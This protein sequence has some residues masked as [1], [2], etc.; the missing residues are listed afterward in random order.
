LNALRAGI[1]FRALAM[2]LAVTST[3]AGSPELRPFSASYS[4][5]GG[6]AE[7]QLQPLGDERWSYQLRLK[8]NIFMRL[9]DTPAELS[10]SVF[11]IQDGRV[12]A[13]QF[14]AEDRNSDKNQSL[15]FD[16]NR[17][18]V[19]GTFERAPVDLPTQPGLLDSLSMQVAL[20]NELQAGR[21][22]QQF[23]LVEKGRIREYNYTMEGSA[24][25]TTAVGEYRTVIY[26][27]TR[28]GSKKSTW[29]WCA[30]ELGHLPLKV[31]RRDGK[32]LEWSM[33]VK[34]LKMEPPAP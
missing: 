15:L 34:T 13:Q 20:M 28:P 32:T 10:R 24:N 12:I 30:P 2:L 8:P 23:V 5:T 11:S 26:R 27:N 14:M 7:V 18:R 33:A 17:G 4:I 29:F 22:P 31:E 25:L 16:W 19:T 6:S 21:T 3:W 1:W 9:F